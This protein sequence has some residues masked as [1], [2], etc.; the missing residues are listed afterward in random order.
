MLTN[1]IKYADKIILKYAD[2][3]YI[4]KQSLI[5]QFLHQEFIKNN[6]KMDSIYFKNSN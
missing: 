2:K 4:W 3:I 6:I 1:Y 5:I